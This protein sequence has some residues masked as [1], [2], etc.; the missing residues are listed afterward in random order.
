[1]VPP[2]GIGEG[3]LLGIATAPGDEDT[4]FVYYT[5]GSDDR[6]G[7][8]SLAGGKV[9]KPKAVLTD[10]PTSTH[11]HGGRLLFD[12]DGMLLVATGDAEQSSPGPGHG[13]A[14]RQDPADPARR[15]RRLGQPVRQ[16][17][18]VATGTATSRASPS[19]PTV[20]CGRPSSATRR[21]TSST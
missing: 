1:M 12:A 2:T 6:V 9:G 16:P 5:T 18:L 7:R 8:V 13:L 19:T 11:H 17:H 20:G 14:G 4:L 10:I 21:P 15:S 3:G